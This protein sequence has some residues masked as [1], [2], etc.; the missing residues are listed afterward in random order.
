MK[1]IFYFIAS[2]IVALGAVACQNEVDENITPGTQNDV[3]SFTVSF[4]DNTRIAL[5]GVENGE[6]SFVFEG[7][8]T[9][10]L[11]YNMNIFEFTNTPENPYTFT[12]EGEGLSEIVNNYSVTITNKTGD[13]LQVA[14]WRY[15]TFGEAAYFKFQNKIDGD[16]TLSLSNYVIHC[17]TGAD[18]V[19]LYCDYYDGGDDIA[20]ESLVLPAN[21]EY[22]INLE[23]AY[24]SEINVSYKI[25]DE[26]V[27]EATLDA[28]VNGNWGFKIFNLGYLGAAT[29]PIVKGSFDSWGDGVTMYDAGNLISYAKIKTT[30]KNTEIKFNNGGNWYGGTYTLDSWSSLSTSGSNM[31]IAEVGTY[32]CYYTADNRCF[33]SKT[34]Q[35]NLTFVGLI[36]SFEGSAW[37]T[38]VPMYLN[39]DWFEAIVT[40]AANDQYKIRKYADWGN[41]HGYGTSVGWISAGG[42]LIQKGSDGN[43]QIKAA[44]TYKISINKTFSSTKI[45]KI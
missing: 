29:G 4:D 16:V 15:D 8:E 43:F 11:D 3:V 33:I 25:N 2:A 38:D 36:G 26:T 24:A 17:T 32:Y 30:T 40:V 14:S 34:K 45:E 27:K 37:R 7:N 18:A 21:G 23:N 6:A 35:D 10:Y 5:G 39:G 20:P 41:A 31:I 22:W 13:D 42:N 44:G 1:K 9:L 12:G 19:T 28:K